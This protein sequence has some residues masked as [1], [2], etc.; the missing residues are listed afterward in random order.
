MRDENR[1]AV[2]PRLSFDLTGDLESV[3]TKTKVQQ[4][5]SRHDQFSRA[6]NQIARRVGAPP[7]N[8]KGTT[9]SEF[10]KDHP[11]VLDRVMNGSVEVITDGHQRF[12]LLAEKQIIALA[13]NTMRCRTVGEIFEKLPV[14]K[15]T[16]L[17]AISIKEERDQYRLPKRK[18]RDVE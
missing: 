15:G 16:P 13:G 14:S 9:V 6:L 4:N 8:D 1:I 18:S 3:M 5:A 7:P 17:R 11:T 10:N 12:V 2:T